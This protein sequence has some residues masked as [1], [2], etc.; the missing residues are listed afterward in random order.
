LACLLIANMPT[1]LITDVV[2]MFANCKHYT[3]L[4]NPTPMKRKIK[5]DRAVGLVPNRTVAYSQ[6]RAIARRMLGDVSMCQPV[7]AGIRRAWYGI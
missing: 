1:T 3:Q 5:S 2:G 6:R 7:L 4:M